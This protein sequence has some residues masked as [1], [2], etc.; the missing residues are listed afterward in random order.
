[1]GEI[2]DLANKLTDI[3]N[4]KA[5]L[6]E[7]S[8]DADQYSEEERKTIALNLE[9]VEKAETLTKDQLQKRFSSYI[10]KM[11]SYMNDADEALTVVGN[12]SARVA[13][14]ENRLT[15]QKETFDNLKS[16]NEDADET[17]VAVQLSSAQVSYEAA[18]M[19]TSDMIKTTLL[20]YL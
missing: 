11:Q 9:A 10:T 5:K 7:M 1:M 2:T 18:L 8:K 14:I 15:D 4:I 19:A 20:N 12:R 3:E 6:E 17:E 13:L 16:D